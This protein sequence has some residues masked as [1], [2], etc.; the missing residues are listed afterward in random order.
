[1]KNSPSALPANRVP[2][3]QKG[4]LLGVTL[5]VAAFLPVKSNAA[6][7]IVSGLSPT[8]TSFDSGSGILQW[9]SGLMALPAG[10]TIGPTNSADKNI[11]LSL[12]LTG[13]VTTASAS[14]ISFWY[15]AGIQLAGNV[16]PGAEMFGFIYQLTE[17]GNN[18][19]SPFGF[20]LKNP[21]NF[22]VSGVGTGTNG[23][24]ANITFNGVDVVIYNATQ[25]ETV[26]SFQVYVGI[27]SP[28]SSVP[29][30]FSTL[31]LL[32]LGLLAVVGFGG[33]KALALCKS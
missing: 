3:V 11:E 21:F 16:N 9:T 23:T 33:R 15:A 12:S 32:S 22:A 24:Q 6:P 7:I 18:V 30:T 20:D 27:P 28:T 4:L 2:N 13:D 26:Q 5:L 14:D 1:M 8:T 10:S 29:D 19:G 17:N 25:L 31:G